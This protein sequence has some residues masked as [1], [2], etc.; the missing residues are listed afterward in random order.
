MGA[1]ANLQST[2]Y[3]PLERSMR[4]AKAAAIWLFPSELSHH[5]AQHLQATLPDL[6]IHVAAPL[7]ADAEEDPDLCFCYF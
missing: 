4:E 3:A 2:L 5:H 1:N 7:P 6:P